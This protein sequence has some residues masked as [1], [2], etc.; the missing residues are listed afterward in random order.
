MVFTTNSF[1]WRLYLYSCAKS[2]AKGE[3]LLKVTYY[4][5][6]F[7]MFANAMTIILQG[8]DISP[9]PLTPYNSTQFD[10]KLNMTTIGTSWDP[11]EKEFYDVGAGVLFFLNFNVP[12]VESFFG[13]LQNIG[14][15]TLFISAIKGVWRLIWVGFII[16][17]LSGRD[18]MP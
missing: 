8:I 18:F 15:P 12:I 10:E 17:F 14:G 1:N 11:S 16:S 7:M 3:I 13:V 6:I 9:V 5:L 4:I 2:E